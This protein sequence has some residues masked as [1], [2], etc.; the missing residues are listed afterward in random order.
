MEII[1]NAK[2]YELPDVDDK[3]FER[4]LQSCAPNCMAVQFGG[5]DVLYSTYNNIKYIVENDIAG[6][7]V[8]CGVWKGGLMQLAAL[9]MLELGDHSRK[10]YLYDTFAGMP[11]PGKFDLDWNDYSPHEMW[12]EHR[13]GES[14]PGL[15]EFGFGGNLESVAE[16]MVKTGYPAENFFFV[17]G[18]VEDTIPKNMPSAIS[19]LRLDTDW[20]ES[21]AHELE[22]LFPVLSVGGILV[23]DDYGTYKG[24]RKATDEYI[25]NNKIKIL[26]SRVSGLGVREGIKQ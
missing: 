10:I 15:S 12:L 19:Y 24:S 17:K 25:F 26:L 8:E 14:S 7:I 18:L 21:T 20:Y 13:W 4:I 6:D 2:K 1:F 16:L 23:V 22:H 3:R 9:T 5:F 11:E